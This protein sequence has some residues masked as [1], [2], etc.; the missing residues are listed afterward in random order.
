[1]T[2]DNCPKCQWTYY[3]YCICP[4]LNDAYRR[5]YNERGEAD[6]QSQA[7]FGRWNY[8]PQAKEN[9]P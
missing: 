4:E 3:P 1:M 5:G 6:A 7:M 8:D 2:D 9:R